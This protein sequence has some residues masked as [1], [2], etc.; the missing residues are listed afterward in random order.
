MSREMPPLL[1][2]RQSLQ[3]GGQPGQPGFSHLLIYEQAFEPEHPESGYAL[4]WLAPTLC[5]TAVLLPSSTML[6]VVVAFVK[7]LIV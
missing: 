6:V 4:H 3:T 7:F 1:Q 2:F 5:Q